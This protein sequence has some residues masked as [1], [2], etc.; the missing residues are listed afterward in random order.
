MLWLTA[1]VCAAGRAK[2]YIS[3]LQGDKLHSDTDSVLETAL[4]DC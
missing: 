1:A 4:L 3:D 2:H